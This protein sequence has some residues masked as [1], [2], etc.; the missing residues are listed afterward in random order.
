MHQNGLHKLFSK[1][2]K[3]FRSS[4]NVFEVLSLRNVSASSNEM[5]FRKL[6]VVELEPSEYVSTELSTYVT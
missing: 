4:I 6:N 1:F 3:Y 5:H 2:Y